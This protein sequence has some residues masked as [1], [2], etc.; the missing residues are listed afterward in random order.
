LSFSEYYK[1]LNIP[2]L[3]KK[4]ENITSENVERVLSKNSW[5]ISDF[6][7]LISKAAEK[8]IEEIAV[9]SNKLTM[10]RFGK[11]IQIYIPLY[12]SNYCDNSCLYCGYNVNN[13]TK[14]LKLSQQQILDEALI[15]K[16]KGYRHILLLTG[17]SQDRAGEKYILETIKTIAPHF[18]SIGL[19]IYPFETEGYKKLIEMGADSLTI[20]QETYNPECYEKYHVSG[21]KRNYEYRLDTPD[22]AGEAKFYRINL[23]ALFGLYQWQYEA[24]SL[25]FHLDYLQKKYWETKYSVSL[26]RIQSIGSDFR[27]P[28]E[29][30]DIEF[31]KLICAFRLIYPDVGINLSTRESALLRDNMIKL[32]VTMISAES[33][34]SPGCYT[35]KNEEKQFDIS[36][37]RSLE[38]ITT[39]LKSNGYDTVMKDWDK[40]YRSI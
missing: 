20:Y 38:E 5:D 2:S 23:G 14:R 29:I 32:G 15:L 37:N 22:R 31:A 39:M 16:K 28:F 19:E 9:K 18:S 4:T 17:E 34:T 40:S 10:Q 7:T 8:Y 21:K 25:A 1:Q 36:D 13:K 30:T 27:A 33:G 6:P 35:G 24:I 26:P 12:I 11:T 3:V